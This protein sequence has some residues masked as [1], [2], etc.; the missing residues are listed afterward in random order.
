MNWNSTDYAVPAATTK[1]IRQRRSQADFVRELPA[2]LERQWIWL[3][4]GVTANWLTWSKLVRDPATLEDVQGFIDD[5]LN[6]ILILIQ[7][8]NNGM[9]YNPNDAI[10]MMEHFMKHNVA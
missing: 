9:N 4:S 6:D 8:N 10:I 1:G 3:T 5:S 2:T 7:N